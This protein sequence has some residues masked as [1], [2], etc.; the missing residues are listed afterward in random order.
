MLYTLLEQEVIPEF[1]SRDQSGIP[2]GWVARMRASMASLTPQ[3]SA[4]RTVREY[5]ENYYLPAAAAYRNRAADQG[6]EAVR[7]VEWRCSLDQHWA[8]LRFGE[9]KVNSD[10]ELHLFEV[11]LYLDGIA[12]DDVRV[13]LYADGI[14]GGAPE[15]QELLRSQQLVG[16]ENGF[17]YRAQ[18]AAQRPASDYVPRVL[19]L[20]PGVAVPLEAAYI[21]WQR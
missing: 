7:L 6:R 1:Y 15:Q 13:E 5:T 21:L 2:V 12:P 18:V 19:A 10:G 9:V 4:N 14:D 11:Q 20:R 17:M 3:Y 8:K 16:A